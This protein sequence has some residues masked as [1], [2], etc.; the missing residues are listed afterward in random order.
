[1]AEEEIQSSPDEILEKNIHEKVDAII[2]GDT[3]ARLDA[4]NYLIDELKKSTS[5]MTSLPKPMKYLITDIDS[6]IHAY[7]SSTNAD[8]RTKLADLLSLLTIVNLDNNCDV[9]LY[10]LECPV[11]NIG[12]WGHE[13]VRC[14]TK[15][16]LR[17]YKN[18]A[19]LPHPINVDP[20]VSQ[21][22]R[23]YM[24]HND[25]PDACDLLLEMD[26]L[27]DIIELVDEESHSRVCTCLLQLYD[28]KP[29]PINTH[30][31]EVLIQIY[32]KLNKLNQAIIIAIKMNDKE[33]A[34]D[35]FRNCED[36]LVKTQLAFILARQLI[37]FDD[38]M[39]QQLIDIATNVELFQRYSEVAERLGRNK[40]KTPD[41]V[42]QFQAS[43]GNRQR[44]D[45]NNHMMAKSFVSAF[46]NAAIKQDLYFTAPNS[47]E[48]INRNRDMGRAVA[49][50]AFGMLNLWDIE[51]GLNTINRFT[52]PDNSDPRV[53]MGGL[54]GVGIISASVRSEYDAAR[55]ILEEP[56]QNSNPDIQV[57]A[58]FGI[59]MAYAGSARDDILDLLKPLVDISNIRVC[60][61]A[62]LAIGLVYVSNPSDEAL[63]AV[64]QPIFNLDD[65]MLD[66]GNIE[67]FPFLAL[68]LGL[69]YLG[70][71]SK[72]NVALEL[73]AAIE[74]PKIAEFFK[75]AIES[76]AYAGTGNVLEIQK[77]LRTCTG[78]SQISHAAA[79]IGI[80]IIALGEP[81]GCQ[82]S[83][84][85]FEHVLQYGKDYARRMI[86]LALALTSI[87]HPLPE[88]VDTL[89]RIGHDT[90][91][92]VVKNAA[93]AL[94]LLGAGTN[95]TRVISTLR[96][97]E[98]FHKNESS[99]LTLLKISEGLT[100]LGQGL[101]TLS[102]TYGD[103]LLIHPVALGALLTIAYASISAEELFIKSDP[104]LMYF[105]APAIGPR[106]LVTLDEELKILPLQVRVGQAVDV[107]GQAGKPRTISGFQTLETPVI[108]E[109]GKRAEFVDDTYEPLS[110][111]LEG[112]VIV[113]KREKKETEEEKK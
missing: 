14:L 105:V 62:T 76:C 26:R 112:F 101:M 55:A 30:I 18:P 110:P 23:Y 16:I 80:S 36:P 27:E 10:R 24:E 64:T 61:F 52:T 79:V 20:L 25:E 45:K 53:I 86:P 44:D 48:L 78:E 3:Q 100:H 74:Y 1:M 75:I 39:D 97:L 54:T 77:L 92:N 89:H 5:S 9:L 35:I 19:E 71:Q 56:L 98:Q 60:A 43:V 81:L 29:D 69:I 82:M 11:E 88:L 7:D 59:A 40:P 84:R 8:F 70:L 109:A 33:K 96:A 31:L 108:L 68:G 57:G 104:L 51:S 41:D 34:L 17:T 72:C 90:D 95:N 38:E 32:L 2:N 73:L 21:I 58:I 49:V 102:P 37:V 94:G 66:K 113:R 6:L 63:T 67:Y 106:F 103:N 107:V 87:S 46:H 99:V 85:M 47:D 28:Y 83:K 111:I 50:A 65:S 12:F 4:I 22:A 91:I 42:L 93:I 13:Y 15:V